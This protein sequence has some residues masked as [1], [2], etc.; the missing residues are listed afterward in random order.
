MND[1]ER[2]FHHDGTNLP[3]GVFFGNS[4]LAT[5]PQ[6]WKS[7]SID[8]FTISYGDP[9]D[10]VASSFPY[11]SQRD[12]AW[13]DLPYDSVSVWA[14]TELNSIERW[15]CAITSV[16]MVLKEYDIKMPNGDVANPDK[17]NTWLS[18][19]PDGYIGN[20]LLNWL[21]ISR[22][23]RESRVAGNSPTDLEFVKSYGSAADEIDSGQYPI[24][25]EGGHFVTLYDHDETNYIV[26]D[27]LD[28]TRQ[29]KAKSD[30]LVSINTYTP[31]DTDLSYLMIVGESNTELE[32]LH[33]GTSVGSS[34]TESIHDDIGGSATTSAKVVM[35][36]KP[37]DGSY[38]L[39]VNI[40][41]TTGSQFKVYAYNTL[42]EVDILDQSAPTGE[43]SWNI[44]YVSTG[45]D[46]SITPLDT[47]PPEYVSTNTFSGWYKTAQTAKFMFSDPNLPTAFVPPTCVISREGK[48]Q[49]C[50]ITANVCDSLKNCKSYTLKSNPAN[51]DMTPPSS[52]K[53]IWGIGMRPM[54]L[55]SW[56][57]S[58]DAINYIVEWGAEKNA[59]TNRIESR[60]SW[61]W[62]PTPRVKQIYVRV[63]AVDRAGN[64]SSPSKLEK[65]NIHSHYWRW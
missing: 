64:L 20:G 7:F 29:S 40:P 35:L 18:T 50:T 17:L 21:A 34:Y 37:A 54:S 51:I 33:S 6:V 1:L 19:Q 41:G 47:T 28:E 57:P 10:N 31:S 39:N 14:G 13:R 38:R 65:I 46:P 5:N 62:L 36:P 12:P 4:V 52:V 30:P 2:E 59:I 63:T 3:N 9:L 24:V 22:L 25:N 45:S 60:S 32:L 16:A 42:G 15:G 53:H 26:N 61:Q 58:R 27:P 23:A 44:N 8:N 11:Y 43:S 56:A 55:V 48:N 49:T